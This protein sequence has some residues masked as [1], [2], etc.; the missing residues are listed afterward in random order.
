MLGNRAPTT[1]KPFRDSEAGAQPWTELPLLP[2]Q[3]P[4]LIRRQW[5]EHEMATCELSRT[6]CAQLPLGRWQDK[7]QV[8]QATMSGKATALW[9]KQWRRT[10]ILSKEMAANLQ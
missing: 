7:E 4:P 8:G 3:V 6:S 9:V 2:F 10:A 1:A 5:D